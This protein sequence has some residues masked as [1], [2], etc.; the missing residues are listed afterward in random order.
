MAQSRNSKS[1]TKEG[2]K[3]IFRIQDANNPTSKPNEKEWY[4]DPKAAFKST[5]EDFAKN[6]LKRESRAGIKFIFDGEDIPEA[7]TA[8][9]L[10][11]EEHDIIDVK[12]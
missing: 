1:T 5:L 4:V 9:D 12:L 11:M 3:L 8:T 10:D 2:L 6:V 7:E